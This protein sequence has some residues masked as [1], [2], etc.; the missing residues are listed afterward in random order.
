[1]AFRAVRAKT[2]MSTA[3]K[4]IKP[5]GLSGFTLVELTVVIVIISILLLFSTPLIRN[6]PLFS[7]AEGRTGDV[8]RLIQQLKKR[9]VEKNMD[10]FLHF[11]TGS[12]TLWITD[13]TMGDDKKKEAR[14]N[15]VRLSG[16]LSLVNV[17]FPD[18]PDTGS[19]EYE[20]A[21]RKSGYTDFALIHIRDNKKNMTLKIEPFLPG[22]QLLDT[23]IHFENCI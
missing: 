12:N 8:I 15:S 13:E 6:L 16:Y 10:F 4:S 18:S 7:D 20:I 22:V 2:K 5:S 14:Q 23:H 21:F 19:R 17:E 3:G 11:D 9:S 1:M